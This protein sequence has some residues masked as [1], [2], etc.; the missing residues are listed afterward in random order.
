MVFRGVKGWFWVFQCPKM[1]CEILLCNMHKRVNECSLC[2]MTK[3]RGI[4][5]VFFVQ[6]DENNCVT[7]WWNCTRISIQFSEL[8]IQLKCYKNV[9]F[10]KFLLIFV[11]TLDKKNFFPWFK[12][13]PQSKI[14]ISY[15]HYQHTYPQQTLGKSHLYIERRTI[16]K[17]YR[18]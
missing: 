8:C 12:K 6:Y 14:S 9:K 17:Y 2:N 1:D 16:C 15:P 4:F 10:V 13:S 18:D 11:L 5:R 7:I 3:I